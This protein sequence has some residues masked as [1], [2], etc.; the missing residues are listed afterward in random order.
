MS[1]NRQLSLFSRET[2]DTTFSSICD[3]L[4]V[5]NNTPA[6]PDVFG[7][8]VRRWLKKNKIPDIP[9]LSLFSGAGGLD[10][11]FSDVGFHIVSS[12]EIEKKFCETLK[13]NAGSG[14]YFQYSHVNCM[15]ICDFTGDNIGKVDFIIGGPPCQT[16]SAAGRR[17]NGVS[18][19]M[20]TRGVLFREYARLLNILSPKRMSGIHLAIQVFS[21]GYR[22]KQGKVAP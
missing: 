10:I 14:K 1:N 12:V 17:A 8:E 4:H 7:L 18:G 15:D 16:F 5:K 21:K 11:G 3:I 13:A 9:T 19:T 20:D 22:P 6:W 2:S